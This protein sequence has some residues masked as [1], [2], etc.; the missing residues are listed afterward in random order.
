MVIYNM[1]SWRNGRTGDAATLATE[2]NTPAAITPIPLADF[3]GLCVQAG[4]DPEKLGELWEVSGGRWVD[5]AEITLKAGRLGDIQGLLATLP[6][7]AKAAVGADVLA[8]I[9]GVI[10]DLTLTAGAAAWNEEDGDPPETF[11]AEWVTATLTA[12]GYVWSGSAWVRT[13]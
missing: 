1:P 11:T 6:A 9:Q 2:A 10:A 13:A 8:A 3:L 7:S 4:A 5:R 12:A